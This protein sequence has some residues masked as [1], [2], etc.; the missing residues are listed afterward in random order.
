MRTRHSNIVGKVLAACMSAT[1]L[2]CYVQAS[3]GGEVE[4]R[5]VVRRRAD[6]E[7]CVTRCSDEGCRT[8]CRERER[9]SREHRCWVE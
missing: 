6:V 7:E 5:N 1:L 9:W 8:S 2:A 3:T 4:C